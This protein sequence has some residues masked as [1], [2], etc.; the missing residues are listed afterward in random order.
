MI[1]KVTINN[2]ISQSE[3]EPLI[4]LSQGLHLFI[5]ITCKK[6]RKKP[7]VTVFVFENQCANLWAIQRD[8]PHRS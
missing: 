5:I 6:K 4:V 1:N 2:S 3:D 7:S 8:P